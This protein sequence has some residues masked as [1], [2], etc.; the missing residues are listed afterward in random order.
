M[1]NVNVSTTRSQSLWG[2]EGMVKAMTKFILEKGKF[3]L[4]WKK[5]NI[6]DSKIQ[7]KNLVIVMVITFDTF[8]F[9]FK[10]L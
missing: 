4:N 9:D 8:A 2:M 5:K 7:K 1:K 10:C 3:N 6:F